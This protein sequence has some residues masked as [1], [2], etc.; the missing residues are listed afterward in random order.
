M[1]LISRT[2]SSAANLVRPPLPSCL[3]LFAICGVVYWS[4]ELYRKRQEKVNQGPRL[5]HVVQEYQGWRLP[6]V[7]ALA[8]T[9]LTGMGILV[10]ML[11]Y[12][13]VRAE[14][15]SH[16][17]ST[18]WGLAMGSLLCS[19]LWLHQRRR[20]RNLTLLQKAEHALS[21][22]RRRNVRHMWLLIMAVVIGI[23]LYRRRLHS[24][25]IIRKRR[26]QQRLCMGR[27]I[28]PS[29]PAS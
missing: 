5:V 22:S 24:I 17:D 19:M 21:L 18:F 15:A 16:L 8:I 2:R 7:I 6:N 13:K 23:L 12:R 9:V 27:A 29:G 11:F 4:Y 20:A 3:M 10:A 25:H 1:R 14:E 28:P 26:R